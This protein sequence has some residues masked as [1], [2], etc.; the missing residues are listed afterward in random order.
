MDLDARI[1]LVSR[2]WTPT[3]QVHPGNVAWHGTG[4]DGSPP[5]DISVQ[6]EGWF[7]ELWLQDGGP[8]EVDGHFSPRLAPDERRAAFEQIRTVAPHGTISLVADAP[9]AETVRAHGAREVDGP[10]FLLQHRTLDRI[11]QPILPPGYAIV[12]A[13]IAGEH[14][15]VDAHRRAWAPARIK[16]LLGLTVT[17]DEPPS[18]FTLDKYRTMK[19]VSIYRPELD[20]VVCS[21]DGRP[22]GFALGWFDHRSGS[23]LFEPVG[24]SPD[25]A[26][27]GLSRAVCSAVMWAARDLGAVQ[28]VVGPRG[29]AAYPAPRRLYESLGFTTVAHT[30]ILSWGTK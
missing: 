11:P 12:P 7:A 22:A 4:C 3:Q 29:D 16:G 8:T 27:R 10:F 9:M 26:R 28:S 1:D 14:A 25:H 18:G 30:T 24:T 5:A 2:T 17:G 15:R 23:V 6:G 21:S 19:R 20:L 13:G